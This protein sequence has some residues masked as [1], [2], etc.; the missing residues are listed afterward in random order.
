MIRCI[1]QEIYQNGGQITEESMAS[2]NWYKLNDVL[3]PGISE[4]KKKYQPVLSMK[5]RYQQHLK[6]NH[7]RFE[8]QVR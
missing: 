6:Q 4:A 5:E 8:F 2:T 1:I 3:T 7:G